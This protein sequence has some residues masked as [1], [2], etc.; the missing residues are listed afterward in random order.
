MTYAFCSIALTF[1]AA[2]NGCGKGNDNASS[3]APSASATTANAPQPSAS[4]TPVVT[5]PP[6]VSVAPT[7]AAL[8][9]AGP[10]AAVEA[11]APKG[12]PTNFAKCCAAIKNNLKTTPPGPLQLALQAA[13]GACQNPAAISPQ[14]KAMFPDCK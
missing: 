6:P 10:D 2:C 14:I 11:G 1:A 9:D 7:P 8:P 4:T 13:L 12:A 5:A 3:G